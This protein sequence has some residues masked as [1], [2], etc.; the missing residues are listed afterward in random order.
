MKEQAKMSLSICPGCGNP[1][2]VLRGAY[3]RPEQLNSLGLE[4]EPLKHSPEQVP[5]PGCR[6]H[7][8]KNPDEAKV[9]YADY[10][11]GLSPG[12]EKEYAMININN[13]D[14]GIALPE[15]VFIEITGCVECEEVIAVSNKELHPVEAKVLNLI[16]DSGHNPFYISLDMAL[17]SHQYKFIIPDECMDDPPDVRDIRGACVYL[18]CHDDEGKHKRLQITRFPGQPP[19]V[20]WM[21][22]VYGSNESG[23]EDES[24]ADR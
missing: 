13:S 2:A 17:E 11:E 20:D 3:L 16:P 14:C 22:Y 9:K 19:A 6:A 15:K 1:M 24:E 5:E 21:P 7:E 10:L 23:G 18:Q 12:W 8:F 4:I